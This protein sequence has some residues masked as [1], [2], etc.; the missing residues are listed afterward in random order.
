MNSKSS[1]VLLGTAQVGQAYGISN[2][3]GKVN[4]RELERIVR[5][6][7]DEQIGGI[8]TAIDYGDCEERLGR[9]GID[10]LP[11]VTKLRAVNEEG[12]EIQEQIIEQIKESIK[13]IGCDK[14]D[15]VLLHRP[16]QL[17]GPCGEEIISGLTAAKE[18]GLT[19]KIGVSAYSSDEIEAAL[20]LMSLDIVQA[21]LSILDQRLLNDGTL[22]DLAEREIEFHARSIF[23]QGLLLMQKA[24]RPS[25]FRK[26]E[27]EFNKLDRYAMETGLTEIEACLGFVLSLEQ[28]TKI[29]VG[30]DSEYQLKEILET[31][32]RSKK[33]EYPQFVSCDQ[34]ELL[35]PSRWKQ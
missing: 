31:V 3:S 21:P 25:Y 15:G 1:R 24:E 18:Q 30:V 27:D 10:A 5:L 4:D 34:L 9:V 26:W 2:K 35:D 33:Y 22:D 29:V 6:A 23:L 7:I 13:R 17:S 11:V 20:H 12:A 8:D 28:V 32:E 14:L 16:R 19:K